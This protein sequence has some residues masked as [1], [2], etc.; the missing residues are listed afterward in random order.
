MLTV[1]ETVATWKDAPRHE[2][3]SL[4]GVVAEFDKEAC[5]PV[6]YGKYEYTLLGV[7]F[8][9]RVL[10]EERR[11]AFYVSLYC[12]R[13]D[14]LDEGEDLDIVHDQFIPLMEVHF[15]YQDREAEFDFVAQLLPEDSKR[16]VYASREC[17]AD[18]LYCKDG[19]IYFTLTHNEEKV[20]NYVPMED[21]AY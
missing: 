9:R 13:V 11:F 15:P 5:V 3:N 20:P 19:R 21:T 17:W 18:G 1:L 2:F 10:R 12:D 6:E 8:D 16:V 14:P 7:Y 4:F